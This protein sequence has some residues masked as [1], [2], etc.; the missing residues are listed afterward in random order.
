MPEIPVGFADVAI[1]F[2]RVSDTGEMVVTFGVGLD[3]PHTADEVASDCALAWMAAFATK[4]W[5]ADITCTRATARVAEEGGPP[6]IGE[7]S[8]NQVGTGTAAMAPQNCA[9]LLRKVTPRGGR[10]G[11]GRM[12]LPWVQ[13][14]DI[15]NV[16][17]LTGTVITAYTAISGALLTALVSHQ[18]HMVLLHTDTD[19]STAPVPTAVTGMFCD[20]IIA[21]QRQR[22]RR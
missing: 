17:Q 3:D 18:L 21:T 9:T 10:R 19:T 16:G 2:L 20:P 4:P 12:Y 8:I 22:L 11:R 14:A 6:T 15:N 13:E 5:T 7:A 1:H